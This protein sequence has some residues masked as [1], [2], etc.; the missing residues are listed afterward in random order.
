MKKILVI[1]MMVLSAVAVNAES[2]WPYSVDLR[3]G[4]WMSIKTLGEN[5]E[6]ERNNVE[7]LK[8]QLI[9][10]DP[11]SEEYHKLKMEIIEKEE[12]AS[13]YEEEY[14]YRKTKD[15]WFVQIIGDDKC[16]TVEMPQNTSIDDFL[17]TEKDVKRIL[18]F[19]SDW[20]YDTNYDKETFYPLYLREKEY[21]YKK[22]FK[23]DNYTLYR[24]DNIVCEVK[25]T[26]PSE[27]E[28]I[29]VY[30]KC[31]VKGNPSNKQVNTKKESKLKQNTDKAKNIHW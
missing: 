4:Y 8:S 21:E 6:Y 20:D 22:T 29:T 12:K 3:D 31:V 19:A 30:K 2:R 7:K 11:Y 17:H 26:S 25:I 15:E 23:S 24:T 1:M 16:I 28:T 27:E 13:K 9:G 5:A 10:L 14:R 18:M